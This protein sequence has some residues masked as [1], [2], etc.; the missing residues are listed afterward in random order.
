[1]CV[2]G[3]GKRK[4]RRIEGERDEKGGE[5]GSFVGWKLRTKTRLS[6]PNI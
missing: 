2:G 6:S 3:E 5:G 4:T 1:M